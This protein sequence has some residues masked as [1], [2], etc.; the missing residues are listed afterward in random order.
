MRGRGLGGDLD[1]PDGRVHVHQPIAGQQLL[2]LRL[3]PVGDHRRGDPV[4][5]HEL[6]LLRPGQPLR[7]DQLTPVGQLTAD[8][9][10]T[11]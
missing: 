10:K 3:G 1:G 4:G 5:H 7:V 8:V 9:A 6:G 2:G 11:P